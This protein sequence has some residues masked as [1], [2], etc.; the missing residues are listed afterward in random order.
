MSTR[1]EAIDSSIQPDAKVQSL[2]NN[3]PLLSQQIEFLESL[4]EQETSLLSLNGESEQQFNQ[5]TQF[6]IA[7][8][9]F[10]LA[11]APYDE[12]MVEMNKYANERYKLHQWARSPYVQ[13]HDAPGSWIEPQNIINTL[14]QAQAQEIQL[15]SLNNILIIHPHEEVRAVLRTT[16]TLND[17]QIRISTRASTTFE[18]DLYTKGILEIANHVNEYKNTVE[19]DHDINR[20]EW[21][22]AAEG[23]VP[24][25]FFYD[26]AL[27]ATLEEA[28]R[29]GVQLSDHL[30]KI[31][32]RHP[33]PTV[34][35]ALEK[36]QE[37]PAEERDM[38]TEERTGV[39][40]RR[41]WLNLPPEISYEQW[42]ADRAP[43]PPLEEYY[44][45]DDPSII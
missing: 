45:G 14:N 27:I 1:I 22:L 5:E 4:Y 20:A 40:D 42:L 41:D 15:S 34:T 43:L 8:I 39:M 18:D 13:S 16:Q 36:Y 21:E 37:L 12:R 25:H 19:I 10:K 28:Y 24:D 3:E 9:S 31:I 35:E 30:K 11:N 26:E 33:N 2:G 38:D 32:V 7:V 23:R 29:F 17:E 6:G 44:E